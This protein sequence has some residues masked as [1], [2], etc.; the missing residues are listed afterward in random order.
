MAGYVTTNDNANLTKIHSLR[1]VAAGPEANIFWYEAGVDAK[2]TVIAANY[3]DPAGDYLRPGDRIMAVCSDG[4]C[5]LLVVT[6]IGDAA[7][8]AHTTVT[9]LAYT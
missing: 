3:F 8:D 4:F 2:A 6:V 1:S 7:N 5:V 9:H